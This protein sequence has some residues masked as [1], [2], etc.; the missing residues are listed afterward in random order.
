[1][2]RMAGE[3]GMRLLAVLRM[4]RGGEH[5]LRA[6][7]AIEGSRQRRLLMLHLVGLLLKLLQLPLCVEALL[8]LGVLDLLL[9]AVEQAAE[10]RRD[11]A[12]RAG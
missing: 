5:R 1:M 4:S 8:M 12:G 7:L 11:A 3:G 10:R 9:W 2:R 6:A